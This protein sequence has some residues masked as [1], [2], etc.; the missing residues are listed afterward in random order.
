[1]EN[2]IVYK[3]ST[4]PDIMYYHQAMKAPDREQFV[5][6]IAD[7]LNAHIEGNHWEMVPVE[8]VPEG[9]I[10]LDSVWAMRRKRDIKTREVYKHKA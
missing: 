1:M 2:P 3:A 4:N 8:D 9:T 6:A 10:I 5:E 7:E